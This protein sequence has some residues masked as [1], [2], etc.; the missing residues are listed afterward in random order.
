MQSDPLAVVQIELERRSRVGRGVAF[1]VRPRHRHAVGDAGAALEVVEP[2]DA[3]LVGFLCGAAARLAFR[4]RL[5]EN[6]EGDVGPGDRRVR[7][8][9]DLD[10]DGTG[11]KG[12]VLLG[13]VF[14]RCFGGLC[15]PRAAA[16][17]GMTGR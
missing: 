4:H 14:R 13:F 9:A 11:R 15:R 7:L 1:V 2:R 3:V 5:L 12:V 10:H 17:R 8:V 16:R 6:A